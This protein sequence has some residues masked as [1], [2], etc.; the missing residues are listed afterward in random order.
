M[1]I[2]SFYITL[3][4]FAIINKNLYSQSNNSYC[5]TI[6][7]SGD[8]TA[9]DIVTTTD[10]GTI[11]CGYTNSFGEGLEDCYFIKLNNLGQIQWTKTVGGN[12]VDKAFSI[13]QTLDGG[14]A[15]TGITQ[16]FGAGG[17][18]VYI[19]KLSSSGSLL[20][21]KTIGSVSSD[22][23]NSIIETF[24]GGLAI[25]GWYGVTGSNYDALLVKLD[26]SGNVVYSKTYGGVG[27]DIANS[28]IE[29]NDGSLVLAG[30][31][32]S[33][34]AGQSDCFIIKT[35]NNGNPIWSKTIGGT[36]Q[37][38]AFSIVKSNDGGLLFVGR[39]QS[40]GTGGND[41]YIVKIDNLGSIV[42]SKT[43]G[44]QNSD[45]FKSVHQKSNGHFIATGWYGINGSNYDIYLVEFDNVGSYVVGKNIGSSN[46]ETGQSL[47]LKNNN[48]L[49]AGYTNSSGS[50]LS[51]VYLVQFDST[52][53]VCQSCNSSNDLGFINTGGIV[54]NIDIL[55]LSNTLNLTPSLSSGNISSG[56][57]ITLI[58]DNTSLSLPIELVFFNTSCTGENE[59]EINW[60]TNSEY[61]S[62]RFIIERSEDA[63]L[64]NKIN[65]KI[66]A[67]FSNEIIDYTIKDNSIRNNQTYYYQLKQQDKDGNVKTYGPISVLCSSVNAD[68]VISP[69]PFINETE[70]IVNSLTDNIVNIEILNENGELVKI[71]YKKIKSGIS[72]VLLE[73][74]NLSQGIYFAKIYVEQE[75]FFKKLIKQ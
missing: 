21:E 15:F 70:I 14:F 66:G 48:I 75:L 47:I 49:I 60:R 59:I 34:G 33:Y 51:D 38:E 12:S 26:G 62:E 63:N 61:N 53:N 25:A 65:D 52:L 20:W 6:G 56:G 40:F 29:N 22:Y 71:Y 37:D 73:L 7:G 5:Q 46:I 35:Q 74:E 19:G 57:T 67:G 4:F 10:N 58:C 16:S 3:L 13:I 27:E 1:K 39:T 69:N 45:Y 55:G 43:I 30:Y 17:N 50:G 8:E 32:T 41:C 64:W 9:T 24:D 31:S 18:D 28:I 11:I 36:S 42:W 72:S 23:G 68:I 44:G 54:S 2:I